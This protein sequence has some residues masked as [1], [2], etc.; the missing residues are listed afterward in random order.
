MCDL[1][2]TLNKA[3]YKFKCYFKN[4]NL[5]DKDLLSEG[6]LQR[7]EGKHRSQII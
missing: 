2:I 3:K 6:L 4:I 5:L 7:K 1:L